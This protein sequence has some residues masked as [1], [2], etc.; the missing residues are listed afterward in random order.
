MQN[1]LY[2]KYLLHAQMH[3]SQMQKRALRLYGD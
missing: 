2:K 3:F 1:K